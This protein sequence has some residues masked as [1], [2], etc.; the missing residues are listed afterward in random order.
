MIQG[1]IVYHNL[2]PR[3]L[4]KPGAAFDK[5]MG[6][7]RAVGNNAGV[8]RGILMNGEAIVTAIV[9]GNAAERVMLLLIVEGALFIAWF[10]SGPRGVHPNL[11]QMDRLRK[12]IEFAMD[13]SCTGGHAL[14]VSGANDA[15]VA[16]GVL[17]FDRAGEDI[18]EDLHIAVWVHSES[19]AARNSILID[20]AKGMKLSVRGIVVIGEGKR[21][22]R[23]EP[24]MIEMAALVGWTFGEH[25]D[26]P[27]K[28]RNPLH[29]KELSKDNPL[30]FNGA[31]KR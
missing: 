13:D 14:H 8:K 26:I 31:F 18:G 15:G 30:H 7:L 10:E 19:L 27:L 24:A 6:D 23:F 29:F 11:E 4:Q 25:D 21:V 17:M 5:M 12:G 22:V 20:N 16:H 2:A 3:H 1:N 28:V 9:R